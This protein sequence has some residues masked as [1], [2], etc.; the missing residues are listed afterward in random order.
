MTK[1]PE[2]ILNILDEHDVEYELVSKKKHDIL[3]IGGHMACALSHGSKVKERTMKN[4]ISRVRRLI[5]GLG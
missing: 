3:Y 5:R 2:P 1:I 4:T